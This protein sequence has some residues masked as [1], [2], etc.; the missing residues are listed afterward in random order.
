MQILHSVRARRA[1]ASLAA[2]IVSTTLFPACAPALAGAEVG[3]ARAA[4]PAWLQGAGK[5]LRIKLTGEIVDR[6]GAPVSDCKVAVRRKTEFASENLPLV[7]E[8]NRFQA[9]VP[10]GNGDWFNV[11]LKATSSDG[12]LVGWQVLSAFE[13]RQSATNGIKLTLKPPERFLDVTVI[14]NARP[15]RDAFVLAEVV[16]ATFTAKTNDKGVARLPLM[17]RDKLSQLT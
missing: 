6:A 1:A 4:K 8:R 9:W 7:T 13:L 11:Q 10:I 16:G 5:D 17:N 3:Q 15:V 14:D 2:I 12:Q